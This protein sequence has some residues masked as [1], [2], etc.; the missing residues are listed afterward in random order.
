MP[1]MV[2]L[3][4][5]IFRFFKTGLLQI[6][7]ILYNGKLR[8]PK[9]LTFHFHTT[10]QFRNLHYEFRNSEFGLVKYK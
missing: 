7:I 2:E 6:T 9:W 5:R 1:I 8:W 10:S 4:T 3:H